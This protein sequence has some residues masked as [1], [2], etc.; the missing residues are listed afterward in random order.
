MLFKDVTIIIGETFNGVSDRLGVW[1]KALE[2]K[3]FRLN[4]TKIENM[5][6]KFGDV[7]YKAEVE[8]NIWDQI[9]S[10]S[11]SFEYLEFNLIS[12]FRN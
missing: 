3:S 10:K 12:L 1:R 7:T 5:E 11:R 4:M 8:V 6:C 9:I 2:A